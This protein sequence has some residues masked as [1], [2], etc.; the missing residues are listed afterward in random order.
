VTTDS[1]KGKRKPQQQPPQK[2]ISEKLATPKKK[3]HKAKET[4]VGKRIQQ[5][6]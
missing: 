2:G 1:G 6:K 5:Q 3:I 4:G